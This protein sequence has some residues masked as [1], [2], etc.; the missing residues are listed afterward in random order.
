MHCQSDALCATIR[1]LKW[2]CHFYACFRVRPPPHPRW[3]TRWQ[4]AT[5]KAPASVQRMKRRCQ[6]APAI[7]YTS[8]AF[9]RCRARDDRGPPGVRQVCATIPGTEATKDMP[10]QQDALLRVNLNFVFLQTFAHFEIFVAT[11]ARDPPNTCLQQYPVPWA[12]KAHR[13]RKLT[14]YAPIRISSFCNCLRISRYSSPTMRAI[15]KARAYNNVRYRGLRKQT[16]AGRRAA[17]RQFEFVFLQ[18]FA[19]FAVFVTNHARSL[20]IR[21]AQQFP[22]PRPAR[23]HHCRATC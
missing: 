22:V 9:S 3:S 5:A 12:A 2:V 16:I 18:S 7:A 17:M 1:Q 8:S 10:L 19:H 20:R 11:D 6:M 23:S 15:R 13:C 14:C 4:T 21:S